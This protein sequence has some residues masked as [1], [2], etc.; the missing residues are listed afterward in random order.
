MLV[1]TLLIAP[2]LVILDQFLDNLSIEQ[3]T[4]VAQSLKSTN[5]LTILITSRQDHVKTVMQRIMETE[6]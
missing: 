3:L 1:R 6:S 2:K 4:L 5:N